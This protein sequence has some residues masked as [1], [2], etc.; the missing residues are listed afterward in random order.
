MFSDLLRV[1]LV[2]Q[3]PSCVW[4]FVTPWTAASQASLS[5]TISWSLPKFM[6]IALVML[7][8]HLIFWHPL[9]LL[10]LIFLSIR[11][12]SSEL[13]VHIRW[14]KCWSFS[15]IIS[16]FSEYSGLFSLKIDRFYLLA[17]QGTFRSLL[18]H[19][20]SKTSILWHSALFMVQF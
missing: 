12:F 13:S 11:D 14:P 10:S 19:H 9:L 6:F 17:V 5:L 1:V 15:L 7:S 4:L 18:Q 3:S 16:P 20:I 2:V 8:K